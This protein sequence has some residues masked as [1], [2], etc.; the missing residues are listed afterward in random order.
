LEPLHYRVEVHGQWVDAPHAAVLPVHMLF[1]EATRLA[2]CL[3]VDNMSWN[4]LVEGY[5]WSADNGAEVE[6]GWIVRADSIR[7]LAPRIGRDPDEVE[8][9]VERYNAAARSGVDDELGRAADRMQPIDRPPFYAVEI[10]AGLVCSTGGA[11]RDTHAR[12]LDPDGKPIPRLYEA[13]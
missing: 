4:V 13:G 7:E 2:D 1:D 10:V 11:R 12:V 6:R 5:R 3:T 8:A 9:T